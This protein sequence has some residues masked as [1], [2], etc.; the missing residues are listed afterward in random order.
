M[1][2]LPIPGPAP[3]ANGA[4]A[5]LPGHSRLVADGEPDVH[6]APDRKNIKPPID[7]TAGVPPGHARLVADS[8]PDK[9][10]R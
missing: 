3:Q 4:N 5:D 1:N 7:Q 6:A 10:E 2:K 9:I 8:K